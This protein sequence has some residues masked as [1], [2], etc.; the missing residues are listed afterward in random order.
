M[1][2]W[3]HLKN[4]QSL[5]QALASAPVDGR[6]H[7]L[8]APGIWREKILVDRA[9]VTFRA[10]RPGTSVIVFD[11]HNGFV[12]TAGH[13][14]RRQRHADDS[15]SVVQARGMTSPTVSTT[16][17]P[18]MKCPGSR[19]SVCTRPSLPDHRRSRR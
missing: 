8:F 10:E 13:W 16:S 3:I 2:H 12:R 1:E 19:T 4:G 9:D 6:L 14:N 15:R 17:R 5:A 11:D 7:I 18:V